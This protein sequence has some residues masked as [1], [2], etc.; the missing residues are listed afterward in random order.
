MHTIGKVFLG[1]NVLLVIGAVLLTAR[2]VN[3]RN[4]WMQQ[5]GQRADQ[6]KASDE[7]ILQKEAELSKLQSDLQR[8]RLAWD[9]VLQAPNCRANPDGTVI[10]GAG[11]NVGFAA[12][13]ADAAPQIVHIFVPQ[14]EST[15]YLGPFQIVN[16]GAAQ[17]QLA[18]MFRVQ[19]EEP[20][21]WPVGTW[22]LWQHVPSDAPSRIMALTSAVLEKREA[23]VARQ[24]TLALQQKAVEQAQTHLESRRRELLGNP[25]AP[26]IED[27]PEVV[28]GLVATLRETEA[29]RNASLVELDRL[30]REVDE[31]YAK[32]TDLVA[33]N[34]R[35]VERSTGD[36]AGPGITFAR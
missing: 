6:I 35:T 34:V 5:V 29:S 10:V 15:A 20:A 32:L 36:V 19:P 14:G 30:R 13:A 1:L 12:A 27:S 24:E 8:Q 21:T 28:A 23:V 3:T 31:S 17:S 7:Q 26:K 16:V 9:T 33:E 4:H 22:R 11:Q 25:Q 18:P 2:L